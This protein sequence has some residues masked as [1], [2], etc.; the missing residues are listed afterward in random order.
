MRLPRHW[1]TSAALLAMV[2]LI[3]AAITVGATGQSE[4][5]KGK[6]NIGVVHITFESYYFFE[7]N[8][9]QSFDR[10]YR[11]EPDRIG[12]R[13]NLNFIHVEGGVGLD[14]GNFAAQ[15][16]IDL[17]VDGILIF[18]HEP[19]MASQ[20]VRQAQAAGIPVAVHG[21]RAAQSMQVP[22]VGFAEYD[23][24]FKLGVAVASRFREAFPSQPAKVLIVNSRSVQADIHREEGFAAGFRS[25][26]P[27]AEFLNKLQDKGSSESARQAVSAALLDSPDINVIY[28]TSDL[29]ALGALSALEQYGRYD[30]KR[31]ILAAVGGSPQAMQELLRPESAWKAEVGLAIRAVAEESYRV[32]IGMIKGEIPSNSDKEYLVNSRVFVQP[33]QQEVEQ[34][35]AENHQEELR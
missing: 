4:L 27:E 9:C 17:G 7:G 34:Y 10:S 29:R 12:R 2:I 20:L 6:I 15:T 1:Q 13:N 26:V 8:Q 23:T 5:E 31:N 11:R 16:L 32:M 3:A 30:P 33:T 22:Y 21:I 14:S 24:C 28:A 18:Q 35:L 25:R 19:G